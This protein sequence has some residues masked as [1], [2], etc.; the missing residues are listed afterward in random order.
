MF[1]K[2]KQFHPLRLVKRAISFASQ[3]RLPLLCSVNFL[4]LNSAALPVSNEVP[5]CLNQ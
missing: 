1:A 3:K 4:K 5:D 2:T